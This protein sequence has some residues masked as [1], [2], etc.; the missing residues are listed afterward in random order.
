MYLCRTWTDG[1]VQFGTLQHV[2]LHF[3]NIP[4]IMKENELSIR[5]TVEIMDKVTLT[6]IIV[7]KNVK[8]KSVLV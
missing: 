7:K 5:E 4:I 2:T 1:M 8:L 6:V 3:I